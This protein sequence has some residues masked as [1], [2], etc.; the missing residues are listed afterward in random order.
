MDVQLL[1]A[2]A[3]HRDPVGVTNELRAGKCENG[4]DPKT[5]DFSLCPSWK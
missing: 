4:G 5:T 2:K 1:V 3:V